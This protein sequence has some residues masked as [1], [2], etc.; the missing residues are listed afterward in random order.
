MV[1]FF[2]QTFYDKNT[3]IVERAIWVK[4]TAAIFS[5]RVYEIERRWVDFSKHVLE[6][7]RF[8]RNNVIVVRLD[9]SRCY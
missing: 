2:G 4:L 1:L 5:F 6:E 8:V 7:K 9:G 3:M